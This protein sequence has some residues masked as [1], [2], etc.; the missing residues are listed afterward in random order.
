MGG[1]RHSI[2]MFVCWPY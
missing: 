2:Y 1:A